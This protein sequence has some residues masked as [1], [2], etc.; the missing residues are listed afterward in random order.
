M[1]QP[2][3]E[4]PAD[5]WGEVAR[6]VRGIFA[7]VDDTLTEHGTL[8]EQAYAALCDARRAGLR[9]VL[10][11]GRP[12]G[13]AEV[14]CALFPIDAAIA[15]NGA[16][17]ALPGGER[18]YF[19]DEAARRAGD[20]ARAAALARVRHELPEVRTAADQAH[21]AI[22]LAFDIAERV[23][24]DEPTI[25]RLVAVLDAESLSTTRSSIHLHG[26]YS[27]GDKAKMAAR[28]AR[29]LWGAGP[30]DVRDRY[31]FVGDSPNDAAAFAFFRHSVGVANVRDHEARLRALGALPA[32]LTRARCGAGFAELV[33]RLLGARALPPAP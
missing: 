20:V 1:L 9:L 11:T 16:A 31:L 33:D 15:E 22:D 4:V 14:L 8:S 21:R 6:N 30:D 26:T 24:L 19:E 5:V 25:A 28:V 23:Q 13:W 27:R 12:L 2:L 10:V 18:L 3:D 32:Y 17:A 7:D 29:H